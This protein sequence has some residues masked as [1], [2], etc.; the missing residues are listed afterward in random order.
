[1]LLATFRTECEYD[2]KNVAAL[3]GELGLSIQSSSMVEDRPGYN[4]C[5]FSF[6]VPDNSSVADM[7]QRMKILVDNDERFI[8][9]HR[10]FQTLQEGSEPNEGWSM[11]RVD[12]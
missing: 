4:L 8:D 2:G 6:V 5:I 12:I 3:L 1:M 7:Q 10:C 11:E 9:M